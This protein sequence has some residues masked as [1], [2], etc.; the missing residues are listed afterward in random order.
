MTAEADH[1]GRALGGV[2]AVGVRDGWA[3]VGRLVELG[4]CTAVARL[5]LSLG[6]SMTSELL[7]LLT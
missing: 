5:R 2:Y 7:Q 6:V 3:M 1:I 4:A